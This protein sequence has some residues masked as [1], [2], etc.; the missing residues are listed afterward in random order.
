LV[1][2][3]YGVGNGPDQNPEFLAVLKEATD[4]GLIIVACTQCLQGNV[5][6]DDY[7][8]GT[9]LARAGVIS[10]YDLTLEAALAK[11]IYLF[12][13]HLPVESIKRLMQT[14]MVGELSR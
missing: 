12:S 6:L 11:L 8:T 2:E 5:D 14:D 9:A 13:Q 3:A 7:A 10:G 4:R 1:L